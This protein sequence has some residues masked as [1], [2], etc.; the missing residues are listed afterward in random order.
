MQEVILTISL[1]VSNR[2]DTIRKCM[3]SIRPILEQVPSELIAIDTVG[4]NTDGSIN[5]VREYTD[6]IY[7]FT[8]CNDFSAARNEGL[9]RA[10]GKW[11]LFMDDDEWFEDVTELIHFFNSGEYKNYKS[12]SYQIHDYSNRQGAYSVGTLNRMVELTT[13]TKFCGAVHE[14][15]TPMYLPCKELTCYIHHYGYVFDTQEE[16]EKHSERNLSLLRPEFEKNPKDL[17]L[18]LQMVQECMYLKKLEAEALVLCEETMQF[19]KAVQVQPAFQWIMTAYVRL[20][21]KNKEWNTVLERAKKIR[22]KIILSSFTNLALSIMELEACKQLEQLDLVKERLQ[23]L[24]KAYQFLNE[25]PTKR[26]EQTI[27]DFEVFLEKSIVARALE[28]GICVLHKFGKKKEAEIWTTKRR[29]VVNCPPLSI[30]LLVS[31]NINTI[32]KC[33]KSIQPLQKEIGAEV[34]VVDTVGEEQSDGSL[35]VA[36][37]Y[38]DNIVHFDW[39]D[40]FSAA[41]NAGL[42]QAKGEWFLFLDDD[43]WFDNV[44]ELVE[45]FRTGEYLCYNSG[46]Y[47][48]RNYKEKEGK[49]YSMAVLARM[50]RRSSNT[51]FIGSVHETFS[52][53]FLPCKSFS[54]F[55]HHFGY[56][57]ENEEEK[58][59]H[60]N[61]NI[62]LLEKELE[63]NPLDLRYR[64]QMA[65]E[66]ATFDNERALAFCEET[67]RLCPEKRKEPEFQWQLS[68]VFR[69][70]EALGVE[71]AFAEEQY[72]ELK[73]K[74]GFVETTEVAISYQMVRIH[75]IKKTVKRAYL[76]A[77]T[78]FEAIQILKNNAELQQLQMT[79]DFQRYQTEQAYLEMLHFGAYSACLAGVYT[80][81]WNWY[82]EMPWEN[83]NFCNEDGFDFILELFRVNPDMAKFKNI[84][85][86]IMKNS[87]MMKKPVIRKKI[88]TVLSNIKDG[89]PVAQ[90]NAP[91]YIKSDMK[92]SI[93][94]LVSNNIDTIRKCMESL[95]PILKAVKSELIVV[96]TKGEDTDGSFAIAKEYADKTYYFKWC[97]DFAAARN[98]CMEHA[99]GEWF[100]FVDDDEW[101]D[102]TSEIIEFFNSKECDNY[103]QGMYNIRNYYDMA[104]NYSES[105]VG[106]FIHRTPNTRFVGI[107][108]ETFSEHYAPNKFFKT[109]AHHSGY[110]YKNEEEKKQHQHRNLSLLKKQLKEE[111]YTPHICSQIVQELYTVRETWEE[112]YQFCL[113]SIPILVEEQGRLHNS[114]T[115]WILVGSARYFEFIADYEGFWNRVAYLRE[116]YQLSQMADLFLSVMEVR[117]AMGDNKLEVCEKSVQR[118]LEL[119]DWLKEHPD[120]ELLQNQLDF[121]IHYNEATY[122]KVLH[123]GAKCA[124]IQ[125]K[126]QLANQYW[127]RFPWNRKDFNKLVYWSDMQETMEG[128]KGLQKRKLSPEMQKLIE[129][130]KQNIRLLM[131]SGNLNAAQELLQ[132]LQEIIPED[133]DVIEWQ[134]NL[135]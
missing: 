100:L 49:T 95:Q 23:S 15:L 85:G 119:W 135:Q 73:K 108:H 56:V 46:T 51:K 79:A 43:E 13:N 39:C 68:L 36:K 27:C 120:D 87:S 41:R 127:K 4:E 17:R 58:M 55:V 126:Y 117:I 30:S 74:F 24:E 121:G 99:E 40:D 20:A 91:N 8:W 105:I 18:R 96:D 12:A 37:Q 133:E 48:I 59:A 26:Q 113:D 42:T 101:F 107:V 6:K 54:V 125:K 14:Y 82:V 112:G 123:T 69:L 104:G 9:K 32:E 124:N 44:K 25:N 57:Y 22:N 97:D 38:A 65:L 52:E 89:K 70:Y 84:M 94:V 7:P 33:M 3:E 81:A 83:N 106:R 128:L 78:Y 34:I 5:I 103:G 71:S 88:A 35:A 80:R 72:T 63:K 93:G 110:C 16:H 131:A 19:E 75:L 132:G 62:T 77:I 134:K 118:F 111:G 129:Q 66:L 114:N 53:L 2:I 60:L 109:V 76:Y 64:A 98:V 122:F 102:D 50:V 21:D 90:T 92:L 61:R 29:K 1:L 45:F 86:R 115:Q 47:Q 116:H 130:L 28:N 10:K 11:F 67:F 31:N